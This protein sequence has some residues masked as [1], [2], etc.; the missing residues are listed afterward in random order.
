VVNKE[1]EMK[2]R[3][4]KKIDV[5]GFITYIIQTKHPIFR[6][7]TDGAWLYYSLHTFKT[8]EEAKANLCYFDGSKPKYEIVFLENNKKKENEK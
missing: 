7:W 2:A 4:V 3:I 1:K 5:D 6:Y 8:L